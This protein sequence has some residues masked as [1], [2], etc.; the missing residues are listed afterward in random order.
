MRLDLAE[1]GGYDVDLLPA[2]SLADTLLIFNI[3]PRLENGLKN[4]STMEEFVVT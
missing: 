1:L 4:V 2:D 3:A